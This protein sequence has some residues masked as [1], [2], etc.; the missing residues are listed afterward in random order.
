MLKTP[1]F[2]FP[3]TVLVIDDDKHFSRM[4]ELSLQDRFH[5]QAFSNHNDLGQYLNQEINFRPGLAP[6]LLPLS[7]AKKVRD[8]LHSGQSHNIVSIIVSDQQLDET[9]GLEL[10]SK[11]KSPFLKKILISNFVDTITINKAYIHKNIDAFL[12]KLDHLFLSKLSNTVQ[13]LQRQFFINYS[14]RQFQPN[15]RQTG[16]YEQSVADYVNKIIEKFDIIRMVASDDVNMLEMESESKHEKIYLHIAEEQDFEDL[17]H[18]IQSEGAS[19]AILR[20]IKEKLA[21]PCFRNGN[22]PDGSMWEEFMRPVIKVNGDKPY[23]ISCH[24]MSEGI[25]LHAN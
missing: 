21:M 25:S 24:T 17:I 20:R 16:L 9:T 10:L 4:I 3:T 11:F 14:E 5:I 8:L 22:I 15:L 19:P 12:P 1:A 23:F 2:F 13:C 18:S 6:E 7:N